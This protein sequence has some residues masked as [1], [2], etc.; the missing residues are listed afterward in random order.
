MFDIHRSPENPSPTWYVMKDEYHTELGIKTT[1]LDGPMEHDRASNLCDMLSR[2]TQY[3]AE[4]N[5]YRI[6]S[7]I[8]EREYERLLEGGE[9][10]KWIP[11]DL[12]VKVQPST[13]NDESISF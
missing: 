7:I 4:P 11:N 10:G 1:M 8:V 5:T 12:P 13:D 3:A 6:L 2:T 9:L